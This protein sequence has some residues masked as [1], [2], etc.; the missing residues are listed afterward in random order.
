MAQIALDVQNNAPQD[1]LLPATASVP[2]SYTDALDTVREQ[3][4]FLHPR[5]L[6]PSFIRCAWQRPS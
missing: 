3:Y 5:G 4:L 6:T 1:P 2:S